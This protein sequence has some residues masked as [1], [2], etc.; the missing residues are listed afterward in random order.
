LAAIILVRWEKATMAKRKGEM[1]PVARQLRLAAA[2]ERR[3]LRQEQR[4]EQQ[5]AELRVELAR[6][7]ERLAK[8]EA[9]IARRQA[10]LAAVEAL[11]KERQLARAAGPAALESGAGEEPAA[12]DLSA[13]VVAV[14]DG[15]AGKTE[16]AAMDGA[17]SPETRS[18]GRPRRG[19]AR[20]SSREQARAN[21]RSA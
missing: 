10:E 12:T 6:D 18:N 19:D 2:N 8:A 4:A 17:P 15:D 21:T 11:L 16:T 9:R 14:A 3:L 1:D 20:R 5:V 7:Q 13:G